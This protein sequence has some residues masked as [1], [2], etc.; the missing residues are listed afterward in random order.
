MGQR[1][2]IPKEIKTEIPAA[3][4]PTKVE[5]KVSAPSI[6]REIDF[7][8]LEE[9][10]TEQEVHLENPAPAPISEF[11]NSDLGEE[12]PKVQLTN[13]SFASLITEHQCPR[14]GSH[15]LAQK[16]KTGV[17]CFCPDGKCPSSE[18]PYGHST[19]N[20]KQAIETLYQKWPKR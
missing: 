15:L 6:V 13:G 1:K 10:E 11:K 7:N 9:E 3:Q 2:I 12:Y 18:S 19:T 16:D 5:T 20:L 8:K 17:I 4:A 14:C